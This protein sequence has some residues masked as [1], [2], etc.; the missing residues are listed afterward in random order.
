VRSLIM[1]GDR[2]L[3]APVGLIEALVERADDRG[4]LAPPPAYGPGDKVRLLSGPLADLV[5]TL[6]RLE[7]G[8]RVRILIELVGG[9]VPVIADSHDVALAG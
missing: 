1:G 3:P 2:P 5:G 4:C 8:A 7:G 6:D 9:V